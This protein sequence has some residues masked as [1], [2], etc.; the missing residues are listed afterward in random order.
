MQKALKRKVLVHAGMSPLEKPDMDR[1]FRDKLFTTNS[2]NLIFQYPVYRALM[3]EGTEFVSHLLQ[4]NDITDEFI[5]RVNSEFDCV[6]LPMANNFRNGNALVLGMTK[7]VKKLKIPCVV[8]GVGLQADDVSQIKNGFPFDAS[9]KEFVSAILDHSAMLGLRG[10]FTG[11]YLKHLG[12]KEEQHFTVTGCPSMYSRGV[13]L[14]EVRRTELTADSVISMNYRKEQPENLLE[15][16]NRG[17]KEFKNHYLVFQRLEEMLMLRYGM[18]VI[19]DYRRKQDDESGYPMNRKHPEVKNGH[20]I[21]F[22]NA[23][24]WR[25]HMEGCDLSIGCR[26]HGNLVAALAGTPAMVFTIDTRT[27]ELCRYHN[28]PYIPA[29]EINPEKSI[30]SIYES[31]DFDRVHIGHEQRFRHF[32]DFL[33]INGLKNIYQE[34]LDPA[35][36]PFEKALAALPEWGRIEAG[37]IPLDVRLKGLPIYGR[38]L[39]HELKAELK[40]ILKK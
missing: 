36:V 40:H 28:I 2:G 5:D 6:V 33:N 11:E 8:I 37:N 38:I 20:T 30:R 13:R 4:R 17:A 19:Y 3:T 16:M 32:V 25:R 23:L 27:E 10:E 1:I 31:T 34:T 7:F 22:A 21:G 26:I 18:P 29:A 15:F 39:K 14:P 9:V 35:D 12:F 24:A